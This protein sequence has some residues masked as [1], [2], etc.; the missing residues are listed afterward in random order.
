MHSIDMSLS[1]LGRHCQGL[2]YPAGLTHSSDAAVTLAATDAAAAVL[3]ANIISLSM[4]LT[5]TT[6]CCEMHNRSRHN[7]Y[8]FLVFIFF[9]YPNRNSS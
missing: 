8:I 9:H 1:V 3:R 5:G 4:H 7:A 6:K 2:H